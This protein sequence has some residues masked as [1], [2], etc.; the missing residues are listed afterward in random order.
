MTGFIRGLFG[1]GNKNNAQNG[2]VFYL[3]Q[4][5]AQSLGNAK[6]MRKAQTIRRTFPKSLSSPD[7]KEL[8]QDVSAMDKQIVKSSGTIL[9]AGGVKAKPAQP[10]S[11]ASSGASN[12]ANTAKSNG[13][14][15]QPRRL[16]TNLDMFRKMAKDV[17]K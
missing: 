6:Y 1:G 4:D 10:G 13:A 12:T 8:I 14:A 9:S 11:G 16:D 7:K 15:P 17:R 2:D 5:E 3:D